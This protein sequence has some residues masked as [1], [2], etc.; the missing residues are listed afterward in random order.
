[1]TAAV[2]AEGAVDSGG[3]GSTP[4]QA[5]LT[6]RGQRCPSA[7][8]TPGVGGGPSAPLFLKQ[9]AE[10]PAWG[11]GGLQHSLGKPAARSLEPGPQGCRPSCWGLRSHQV[12]GK[13]GVDAAPPRGL[14]RSRLHTADSRG[15][16]PITGTRIS[17]LR[18]RG[19]TPHTAGPDP[20]RPAGSPTAS[21]HWRTT[22]WASV[23]RRWRRPEGGLSGG[24]WTLVRRAGLPGR[25]RGQRRRN[26]LWSFPPVRSLTATACSRA[27]PHPRPSALL[28][29]SLTF[30]TR[31]LFIRHCDDSPRSRCSF[32][33]APRGDGRGSWDPPES[34]RLSPSGS[35][36][37]FLG[38]PLSVNFCLTFCSC[39][40][41]KR[42]VH[43]SSS[44]VI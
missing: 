9:M 32:D 14:A 36:L 35:P 44:G 5:E 19:S 12:P 21:Q 41:G 38:D 40:A 17:T 6:G 1:M 3:S 23:G 26:A 42:R 30:G 24:R 39:S 20:M 43:R 13:P 28:R 10:G 25:P 37:S 2:T 22:L 8:R 29:P 7:P 31:Q 15:C 34:P 33:I 18:S 16:G 11:S 27:P 4:V